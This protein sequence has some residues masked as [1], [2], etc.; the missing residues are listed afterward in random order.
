MGLFGSIFKGVGKV[1]GGVAK[2]GIGA[3]KSG[4]V[5]LPLGGTAG[6]LLGGLIHAKAPGGHTQLK[7]RIATPSILRGKSNTMRVSVSTPHGTRTLPTAVALRKSPV[8]PGGSVSTRSGIVNRPS[9]GG[10][11]TGGTGRKRK[12]RR[13]YS[14]SVRSGYS[15]RRRKSGSS[16]RRRRKLKF[17]SPAW[18]K[19]YLGHG[20]KRR[21]RRAA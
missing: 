10:P 13:H 6:R 14:D 2:V 15:G 17:G 9:S 16:G 4:L 1:F 21:K 8:M 3:L 11:S 7:L 18:R 12:R 20:R 5:P 19:K